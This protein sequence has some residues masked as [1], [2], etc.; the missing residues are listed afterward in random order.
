MDFAT[1]RLAYD[2]IFTAN[3]PM[4]EFVRTLPRP[5]VLLSNTCETHVAWIRDRFPDVFPLFDQC[6]L[7]NEVGLL[8][9]DLAIYRHV[10]GLTGRAPE[11]HLFFDDRADNVQAAQE[12]G[13][14]RRHLR[15]C[16]AV[17]PRAGRTRRS[18]VADEAPPADAAAAQ[19]GHEFTEPP[20][21]RH[22]SVADLV[23]HGRAWAV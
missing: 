2:D 22:G 16:G 23:D 4:V 5:W 9:P 13:L 7:S 18:S 21:R 3:P 15:G 14:A 19:L 11:A 20:S 17:P 8:K 12:A 10:E 1:F 6:V